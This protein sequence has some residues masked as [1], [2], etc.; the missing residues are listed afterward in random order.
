MQRFGD[1]AVQVA[2]GWNA[3]SKELS[4]SNEVGRGETM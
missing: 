2:S 3:V 1:T 4:E